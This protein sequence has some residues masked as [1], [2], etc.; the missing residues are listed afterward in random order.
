MRWGAP[1]AGDPGVEGCGGRRNGGRPISA[2]GDGGPQPAVRV[3]LPHELLGV[4]QFWNSVAEVFES[5]DR[6]RMAA[7]T[8]RPRRSPAAWRCWTSQGR[9]TMAGVSRSTPGIVQRWEIFKN[10]I[11][12]AGVMGSPRRTLTAMVAASDPMAHEPADTCGAGQGRPS[13]ISV[14]VLLSDATTSSLNSALMLSNQAHECLD[15]GN[16]SDRPSQRQ[17]ENLTE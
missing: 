4:D 15:I 9:R 2:C 5:S 8:S 6:R 12:G 17:A 10:T 7:H 3:A 11:R 16:V 14:S 1:T 13:S